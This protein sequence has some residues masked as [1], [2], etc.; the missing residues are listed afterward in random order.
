M[1]NKRRNP[2][3]RS[4]YLDTS[5]MSYA[6]QN[7]EMKGGPNAQYKRGVDTLRALSRRDNLCVSMIHILEFAG[8]PDSELRKTIGRELDALDL[9]WVFPFTEVEKKEVIVWGG[10]RFPSDMRAHAFAPSLVASLRW[11]GL[12]KE[13]EEALQNDSPSMVIEQMAANPTEHAAY[14]DFSVRAMG[15]L[16]RNRRDELSR[17][18]PAALLTHERR[19]GRRNIERIV[20]DLKS[21][22]GV[23]N[24]VAKRLTRAAI[25]QWRKTTR[26][27]PYTRLLH[28]AIDAFALENVNQ[29]PKSKN[30]SKHASALDDMAHLVGAAY[31]DTFTC[32]Q[33]TLKL[34]GS[35]RATLGFDKALAG[36]DVT[37]WLAQMRD[38]LGI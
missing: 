20:K 8:I 33:K 22:D 16:V 36:A 28:R 29:D 3:R 13:W 34:I 7:G 14:R 6:L 26:A 30:F 15:V 23:S 2:L 37:D 27:F 21:D 24:N 17:M 38:S 5:H 1:P 19:A 9:V 35:S 10:E 31:C 18:T 4:V 12:A 11:T 25:E 32:D